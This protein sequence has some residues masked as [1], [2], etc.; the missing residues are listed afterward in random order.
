MSTGVKKPVYYE[1]RTAPNA[2]EYN[3]NEYMKSPDSDAH[4][5]TL[6]N[7]EIEELKDAVRYLEFQLVAKKKEQEDYIKE[8]HQA[9][10]EAKDSE[11]KFIKQ[12]AVAKDQSQKIEDLK[13][14]FEE[15][16]IAQ[17]EVF[18]L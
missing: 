14:K 8:I 9:H 6:M 2:R 3:K 16:K 7:S 15:S 13:Q 10:C 5:K 1:Q 18:Q 11:G 4:V 12:S 17:D